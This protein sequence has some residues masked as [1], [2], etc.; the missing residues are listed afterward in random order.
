MARSGDGGMAGVMEALGAE[1]TELGGHTYDFLK[2]DQ[3]QPVNDSALGSF[4]FVMGRVEVE[5]LMLSE[6][7]PAFEEECTYI[8]ELAEMADGLAQIEEAY[9]IDPAQL[10]QDIVSGF[11][12]IRI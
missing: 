3:T 5:S 11:T 12:M 10:S 8:P 2:A 4:T 6:S 9:D 7:L 1:M